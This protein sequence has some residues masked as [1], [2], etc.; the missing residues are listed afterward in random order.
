LGGASHDYCDDLIRDVASRPGMSSQPFGGS[1]RPT[2]EV[3]IRAMLRC[4]LLSSLGA[5]VPSRA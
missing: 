1:S 2:C 4:M 3:L 5:C